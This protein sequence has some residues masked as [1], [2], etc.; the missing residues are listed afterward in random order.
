MNILLTGPTGF[1]GTAFTR[2]ALR[3]GHRV[4]GLLLPNE[5]IPADRPAGPQL[6]WLRGLLDQAPWEEITRFAPEVC[7]H[8]A[9]ITTPGIYLETPEN[10]RFR[11]ASLAFIKKTVGLGTRQ[12]VSLGTCVEYQATEQPMAEDTSPIAPTTLYA[13]C[14]N[15]LRLALEAEARSK[16]FGFCWTRIF[17]PYGPGEHPSRLCSS[18]IHKLLSNE[19]V[20]LRTPGSTKDY[21]FIE[22]LA[23]ALLTVVERRFEG[24]INLGSGEGIE[25]RRL[26]VSLARLLR[27]ENLVEEQ[28][29]PGVD[30]AGHV[31]ADVTKL[32]QLGWEP[33]YGLEAGLEK[34]VTAVRESALGAAR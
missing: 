8:A 29:P 26:A 7:V 28:N 15:D 24:T 21:I 18:I 20:V 31:V 17:Y 6:V 27:K 9:W 33:A 11:D 4:A 12:I 2:L 13:R 34:L 22:D 25:V 10:E 3:Q 5:A 1:I 23:R 14:K 16:G 32:R 19:K 30:P